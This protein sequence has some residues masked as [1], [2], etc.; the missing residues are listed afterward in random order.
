MRTI[1]MTL[2]LAM[3]GFAFPA[4]AGDLNCYCEPAVD[5]NFVATSVVS[6]T[7]ED[8]GYR[9]DRIEAEDGYYEVQAVNESG[10]PIKAVFD[11]ATGEMLW[12]KLRGTHI[13]Y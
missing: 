7:L 3:A 4:L 11:Q 10:W 5:G 13:G 12:A 2:A 6:K 9:V 1:K 8:L